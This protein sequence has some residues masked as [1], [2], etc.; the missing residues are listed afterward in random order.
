MQP[1]LTRHASG[2]AADPRVWALLLAATLTIMSNATISPA[3][4]GLEAAFADHPNAGE[5]VRLLVTAPSLAVALIAPFAGWAVDRIGRRPLLLGGVVLYAVAGTLGGLAPTLEI[6]FASRV[7]LGVAVAAIM[8]AQSALIGDYFA[9]PDRG[10]FMGWQMAATNLGG[11]A[12]IALAGWAAS[13]SPRLPFA[14]YGL[15][16]IYLPLL[17]R[18]LPEP[19]RAKR[20]PGP[21]TPR[22]AQTRAIHTGQTETGLTETDPAETGWRALV[23]LLAG[24]AGVTFV[25]F[26]IVPTQLPFHMADIGLPAPSDAALVMGAMTIAGGVSAFSF[27][28]IRPVL[29]AGLTPA[30]GYVIVAF[31]FWAM[32][33]AAA[34]MTLAGSAALTGLGL[35]LVMPNFL[36]T[37]L[38]VAPDARRGA[39]SGAMTTAIFAGQFLSPIVTGPLISRFGFGGGLRL[40]A[41]LAIGLALIA[42]FV[43]RE[44]I[45]S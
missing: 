19:P 20:P 35:G 3:L 2:M 15:G 8:T 33:S 38:N 40:V 11:F 13:V 17:W 21:A 28:R 45:R 5:M 18:A 16:L 12:F 41:L 4:P 22:M 32:S 9:G 25:L 29:G 31:G 36:T 34:M 42:A 44:R 43:L 39:V 23:A 1:T 14:L 30:L 6:L 10:R 24:L 7:I 37:A 27:G 26:Y